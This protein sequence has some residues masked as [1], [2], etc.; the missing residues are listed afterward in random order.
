MFQNIILPWHYLYAKNYHLV[1]IVQIPR[2]KLNCMSISKASFIYHQ[3]W[4]ESQDNYQYFEQN[5]TISIVSK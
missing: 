2:G 4:V 3:W 5:L 1:Y